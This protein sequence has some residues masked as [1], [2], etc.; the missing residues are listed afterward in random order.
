MAEERIITL[1]VTHTT[2]TQACLSAYNIKVEGYAHL[3]IHGID[4]ILL[5]GLV[6]ALFEFV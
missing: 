6:R 3:I 2:K 1:L 5:L 4:G